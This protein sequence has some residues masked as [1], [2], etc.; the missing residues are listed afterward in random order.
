VRPVGFSTGA[1]ALG[2]T[3]RA[4]GML[5]GRGTTAVELSALRLHELSPLLDLV[6]AADLS[7]FAY[8]SVHAPSRYDA[9]EERSVAEALQAIVPRGFPIVVHPDTVHDFGVWRP[10]GRLIAI[11]N[12]DR[13]KAI[14]RTAKELARVFAELPEARF[15]FDI[16]HARQIDA[17]MREARALLSDFAPRL[18]QLHVSQVSAESA[19]E[20]MSAAAIAAF[21]SVAEL[22]PDGVPIILETPAGAPEIEGEVSL[23]RE[24]LAKR[25]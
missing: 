15:C 19:H 13:R 8:V 7:G 4:L 9:E 20:R 24:A 18:A 23:A 2:D 21:Q 12:M 11:E 16:G 1:L 3:A 22:V 6:A 5:E 25:S 10:F 17:S 14:G